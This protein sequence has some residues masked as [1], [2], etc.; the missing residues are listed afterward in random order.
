MSSDWKNFFKAFG[1]LVLL[2]FLCMSIYKCSDGEDEIYKCS[3]CNREF[4]NR[5]DVH[6][7]QV[8]SM[9]EPCYDDF[10]FTKEFYEAAKKYEERNR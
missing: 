7:I 9:C 4:T 8:T 5:D 2:I 3:S 10:K 1:I 6:S